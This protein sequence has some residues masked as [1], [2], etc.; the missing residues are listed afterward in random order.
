[1]CIIYIIGPRRAIGSEF[2]CRSRDREL[3]PGP[4]DTVMEIDHEIIS[5]VILLL[6]LIQE[7]LLSVA[8]K[9]VCAQS[10]G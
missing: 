2:V 10:M 9:S 5:K 1:M 6:L 8:S 7:G 4:S 3:D